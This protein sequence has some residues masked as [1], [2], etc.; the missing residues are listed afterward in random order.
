MP[1]RDDIKIINN[2]IVLTPR[3][4]EDYGVYVLHATN[5]FGSTAYRI[6]L[7]EGDK[8]STLAGT[9][10]VDGSEYSQCVT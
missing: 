9:I 1:V 2:N 3:D 10:K 6:T 8:S 4:A 7:L 5:R